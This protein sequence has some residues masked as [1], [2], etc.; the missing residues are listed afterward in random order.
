MK[1]ILV[2]FV[3]LCI[4]FVNVTAQSPDSFNYQVVVRNNSGE[5]IQDQNI[6]FQFTILEGSAS[7]SPVFVE[8]HVNQSNSYGLC[9]LKIGSGTPVSG[10][11]GSITWG[12]NSYFLQVEIDQAGG[13][14]YV[15][16][17]AFELLTVPYAMFANKAQ[18]IENEVLYFT[19]TDTLFA[20]K[21]RDGNIVFAVFPDG[22]KVY[23]NDNSK[24]NIGGFAV[25]GRSPTKDEEEDIFKVTPDS[26]RIWI[27]ED[28]TKGSIG[29]FAVSGR[30][31]TKS[32]IINNYFITNQDSTRI[33][34]NDSISSKGS[35]GG[36]AVSG[37][38][39][40]K[41][42]TQKFMDISKVNY[43]IGHQSGQ[44]TL[45]SPDFGNYN[46]FLGFQTGM[47]NLTGL[48]NVFIGY[49]TAQA[50]THGMT[51]VY[52]G[53]ESGFNNT[54][55][56]DNVFI[57]S[58]SGYTNTE[59]LN[60]VFLGSMSGYSNIDGDDNVFVG[61]ES[62]YS[63][64]T[65]IRN[66][67]IGNKVGRANTIGSDNIFIGELSGFS[68]IDGSENIF[69]GKRTGQF[70]ESAL[71]NTL[72]GSY[73]GQQLT[74]GTENTF[75]GNRTGLG[76]TAGSQNTYIGGLASNRN[77]TG[78][79]NVSLGFNAG[80][81]SYGSRNTYIG[82]AAGMNALGDSSVFIG[83]NAGFSEESS[84][85][86][87]IANHSYDDSTLALIYGQFDKQWLRI[88]KKL[89][90]NRN[91]N[92]NAL[93]VQGTASKSTA[94]DWLA[95]SDKRIKTD[96]LDI[97]NSFETILKLRPVKFKYTDYWRSKHSSI[98]DQYYYNFIAQEYQQVFPQSVKG[99]GE[100]IEGD[101]NE[102]LQ[103][104]SYNA[105]IVTV[106][107]VQE[108]IIENQELKNRLIELER[109]VNQLFE[110]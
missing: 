56:Y 68:N 44:K 22:A 37:R 98:K 101:S 59:G 14:S 20:V 28:S 24:G 29:G 18:N 31:P 16:M 79:E 50:N 94:G 34:V 108:L 9:N 42:E 62:G 60:N 23:V 41:G 63:N 2:F 86:L 80:G 69:I 105:Q 32:N 61:F 83:Y 99:S 90:V 103:L 25:S 3:S 74:I 107:A 93:E 26:T 40:T 33:Y 102:I 85:R 110:K 97:E 54:L 84:Q 11:L 53:A 49:K 57:G 66:T 5:L 27:R 96:I 12:E 19:E 13:E 1:K 15:D 71:D 95:N 75:L 45:D 51:N 43:F 64:T 92:V 7:G 47:E 72:I 30:S 55:G 109:L 48:K 82:V 76:N 81:W 89:G 39:P 88:N 87:Y 38:S 91:P 35:V 17:G 67:F 77:D 78:S 65:G 46:V 104:D 21:D 10:D 58:S 52:I 100:Y 36:F 4:N 106:K 8:K 70:V 6:G 73:S